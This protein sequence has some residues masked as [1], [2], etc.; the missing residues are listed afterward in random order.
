MA[1]LVAQPAPTNAV[2]ETARP[3]SSAQ[4]STQKIKDST[5]VRSPTHFAFRNKMDF[6]IYF[7]ADL[8]ILLLSL[9]KI[10]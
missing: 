3:E 10:K 2:A 8:F 5:T 1:N 9:L 4:H 6:S 7:P